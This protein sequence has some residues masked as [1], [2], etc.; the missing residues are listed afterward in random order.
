MYNIHIGGNDMKTIGLI[1]GMSWES[2]TQY[3]RI[4]NEK[5]NSELG[6]FSSGKIIL[7][8]VDFDEI[9]Y[10]MR[11]NMWEKV[12]LILSQAAVKLEEAGADFILIC[13]NTMHKLYS[14]IQ[15][16][17]NIE[18][19]HI[20]DATAEAILNA[21]IKKVGLLGT[22]ATMEL[23]FYKSRLTSK[24][25]EVIIP[26]EDDRELVHNIIFNELCIGE[27]KKESRIEYKRIIKELVIK[28]ADGII[29][30]CT[31]IPLLINNKDSSVPL[32]DTTLIHVMK[33]VE[34][35]LD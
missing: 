35:S 28:G 11:N 22:K 6:G 21:N 26:K 15:S 27:I 5:I 13:T 20:A 17:L 32:F 3:Y 12:E 10:Y 16:K 34:K 23:E 4:I 19:L 9:E 7:Y 18:I 1:G 31:E 8:S 25:I 33:A 2:T 14:Q 30:G 24:G 29:L